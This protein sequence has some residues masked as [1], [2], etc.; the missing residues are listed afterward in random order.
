VQLTYNTQN[1]VGS[2]CYEQRDS[3]LSDFGRDVLAEMNR[4]GILCD[5][6][7]V[8][9]KTS[10]DAILA[11]KQRVA[12]S[13]C[14]PGG[15][16]SASAQ[17]ERRAAA[18]HRRAQRLHRRH[19]VPGV[20]EAGHVGD[21]RRLRRSHRVRHQPVRRGVRRHRHR[22][23][24]RLRRGILP[25]DHPRQ[26]WGRKLVDFGP[27]VNPEGMRTIGDFPISPARWR[28]AAGPRP[29]SPR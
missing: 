7:H 17:Q 26:G 29:A 18:L 1:L 21:R 12:Y 20:P 27:I 15:P 23:H 11:S 22:L 5:L 3:G 13:H 24:A 2:G 28:S 10:E 4:L 14:L 6:S 16:E 9:A 8:G 19:H 25:L